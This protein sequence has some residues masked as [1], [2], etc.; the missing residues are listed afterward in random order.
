[1]KVT[2]IIPT[3][4]RS[5]TLY[6]TIR[7]C[8]SQDYEQYEI[9]VSD[10]YSR[11]ETKDVVYSFSDSRIRYIN[12]GRRV[13]MSRNWEFA[14]SH[15]N[16]GYVTYLGDDDGLLPNAI[17]EAVFA[18]DK[19]KSSALT[20]RKV[21][22]CWPSHPESS[23]KNI[24]RISLE[25]QL[26][27]CRTDRMIRDCASFWTAYN[28]APC[29]Y[30]SLVDTVVTGKVMKRT[31]SFFKSVTPDIYSGFAIASQIRSYMYSIRPF[32]INGAS[33]HSGGASTNNYLRDSLD[34][35]NP[36]ARFIKEMDMPLHPKLPEIIPGSVVA[37]V[38]EALLQAND[39]CYNGSLRINMFKV[40]RKIIRE[41]SKSEPIRYREVVEQL[42]RMTK[43][44]KIEKCVIKGKQRF[45]NH[46][47]RSKTKLGFSD[48]QELILD[49]SRFNVFNVYDASLLVSKI[50][51]DYVMPTRVGTYSRYSKLV[52]KL[53]L[54]VKEKIPNSVWT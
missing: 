23:A 35:K 47:V 33:R 40:I 46:P 10:N 12:T 4:E 28:R 21:E 43:G 24:L 14:L 34:D 29:I 27:R 19:T 30:N 31:G 15:V 2:V 52:G 45:P 54:F 37:C 17:R 48:K 32:S 42:L 7:T 1:M 11:D 3:R 26:F 5:D 13:S 6:H 44:T 50:L 20:W 51:G 38:A 16:E 41:V 18:I 36:L 39:H 8:L 25:N 9:L 22:Y 53:L 49:A